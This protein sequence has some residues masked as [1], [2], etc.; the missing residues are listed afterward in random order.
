MHK[1]TRTIIAAGVGSMLEMYDFVIYILVA[2]ILSNL[3]FPSANHF[4]SLMLT[5]AAFAA[6]FIARPFGS[7]IFGHFGDK[8]GRKKVLLLTIFLMA[9]SSLLIAFMPSYQYIGILHHW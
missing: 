4:A 8:L 9:L 1:M 7:L 3:F 2:S 6:G 5:L